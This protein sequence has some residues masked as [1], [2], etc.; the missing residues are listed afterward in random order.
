MSLHSQWR[1]CSRPCLEEFDAPSATRGIWFRIPTA[2]GSLEGHLIYTVDSL[3]SVE[4]LL[5]VFVYVLKQTSCL[6]TE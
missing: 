2:A 3:R 6:Y 4:M 1:C 5:T